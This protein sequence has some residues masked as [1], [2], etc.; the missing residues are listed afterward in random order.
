MKL[1]F[2][3]IDICGTQAVQAP[4]WPNTMIVSPTPMPAVTVELD[5]WF[6]VGAAGAD[7]G[8][9]NRVDPVSRSCRCGWR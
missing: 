2:A 9:L 7:N 1:L 5:V 8:R 3:V 4:K 6:A